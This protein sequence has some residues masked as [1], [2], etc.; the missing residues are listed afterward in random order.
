M[1]NKFLLALLF[2]VCFAA[3]SMAQSISVGPRVGATFSKVALSD[4]GDEEV[5]NDDIKS[6]PG[7]QFGAVANFMISD[8]FSIQ[9]ELLYVQKGYKIGEDDAYLKGKLNYIEVPVLAKITF[10]G[11]QVRG[12]VTGGPTL[13]YWTGGKSTAKF[14]S[15][16]AS[17]DYEFDD[18]D[19]RLELGASFGVGTAFKVGPGE[20]NL[21]VRY[22]LGFTGLSE[23]EGNDPKTRNRVFGVSLA[24]LFNL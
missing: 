21:D 22:G 9:P 14:G 7:I 2:V 11:E 3:T 13:G 12:F 16:E 4:D 17:E 15:M 8:M 20:L 18:S 24:Y 1:K 6:T 23:T 19:N 5:T 10:G